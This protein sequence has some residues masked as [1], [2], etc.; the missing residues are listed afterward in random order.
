MI[1]QATRTACEAHIGQ[2]RT[3]E[4][5]IAPEA[6]EKMS[7]VLGRDR[8]LG[9]FVPPLWHWAY[10]NPAVPE[11][12]QGEDMH[13]RTGIFLPAAPFHRRMR[14]AGDLTFHRRLEVG[15]KAISTTTI[16]SVDFKEGRSGAMCF[17]S[18]RSLI[19]Q[20]GNLCIDEQATVVYRDR[21][22]RVEG[23]RNPDDPIPD[24]Y[25][26]YSDSKL[27][28]YSGVTFNGHRIHW[29]RHFCRDVEGYPDLVVHGP[30]MA[31]DLCDLML[32]SFRPCR[33]K[34]RAVAPVFITTP[35]RLLHE[36]TDE[37]HEGRVERSD[38]VVS[39]E[40]S[41]TFL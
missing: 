21:G 26:V 41:L 11:D 30:L 1:D 8:D 34:Y 40:A 14:A 15:R 35:V 33:F 25:F 38:G 27:F 12:Q 13:E 22:D 7:V 24:G 37:A 32:E 31:T 4:D 6:M 20:D 2:T 3:L 9:G 23:L 18:V 29:D 36:K 16:E 5:T 19:E 39:M 28:F 17:V 10:F